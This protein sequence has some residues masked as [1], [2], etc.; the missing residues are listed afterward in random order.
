VSQT[1]GKNRLIGQIRRYPFSPDG[2]PP[3]F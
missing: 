3:T 1:A 2:Y